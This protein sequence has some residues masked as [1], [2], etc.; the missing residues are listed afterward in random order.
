M[1]AVL[2][3][4]QI[5]VDQRNVTSYMAQ[6]TDKKGQGPELKKEYTHPPTAVFAGGQTKD[7]CVLTGKSLMMG[8]GACGKKILDT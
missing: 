8:D 5:G 6:N 4:L 7:A 3:P 2:L 1:L